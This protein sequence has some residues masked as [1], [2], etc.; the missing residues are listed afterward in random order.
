MI[1]SSELNRIF[2]FNMPSWRSSGF[3]RDDFDADI[4]GTSDCNKY[5]PT[6]AI[7]GH[8]G[9][10]FEH[11]TTGEEKTVLEYSLPKGLQYGSRRYD[12]LF[13]TLQN[14]ISI[15]KFVFRLGGEEHSVNCFRGV[16][17]ND[18]RDILLCLGIDPEYAINTPTAELEREIDE[19]QLVLF[20][21]EKLQQPRY[22]NLRKK[23]E[24]E[25]IEVAKSKGID[26]IYTNRINNW[27]FKNNFKPPKFRSVI[28]M[29]KH[30]TEDI[31]IEF[32]LGE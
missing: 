2:F 4:I 6:Y 30:L 17:Y 11:K 14:G 21:S 12:T 7:Y 5:I 29:N 8:V 13:G 23:L 31:P 3:A 26:V 22:K 25:Y 10:V 19:T 28:E 18:E 9:H 32:I 15:K 1:L 24:T 27:L 16:I 20:V